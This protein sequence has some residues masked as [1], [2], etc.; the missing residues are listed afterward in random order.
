M[1]P[2]DILMRHEDI[3]SK[4]FSYLCQRN[5]NRNNMVVSFIIA[6]ALSTVTMLTIIGLVVALGYYR[7]RTSELLS[8][9]NYFIRANWTMEQQIYK[10]EK[11]LQNSN[12][13]NINHYDNSNKQ[14]D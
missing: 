8:G 13:L 2:E 1:R 9:I 12:S 11:E 14:T 7:W 4:L 5:Q 10:L 3:P 6:V